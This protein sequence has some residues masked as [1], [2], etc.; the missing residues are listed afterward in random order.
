MA[1]ILVADDDAE[2]RKVIRAILVQQGLEVVQAGDGDDALAM[3]SSESPDLIL[4][5]ILM[6]GMNGFDVLRK[7]KESKATQEIP[8]IVIS[9]LTAADDENQAMRSGA[10]DYVT[11]PWS[12]GELEDR[13][14]IALP[15]LD[16]DKSG[17]GDDGEIR[18][19]HDGTAP[20]PRLKETVAISTGSD[21][22]DKAL[23]GGVP[24]GSLT[25]LEGA[26]GTGKSVMCQHLAFGALLAEQGVAYYVHGGSKEDL[27]S[28]M[29]ELG[30][31]VED[32]LN[33]G[34]LLIHQLNQ[35]YGKVGDADPGL[36]RLL[37]HVQGLPWDMNVI[38]MDSLT[39][40]VNKASWTDTLSFLV[41]C[42]SL[43]RLAKTIVI[44]LHTSAF[45]P[46]MLGKLNALFGTHLSFRVEGFTQ[47]LQL[48]TMNVMEV[49]K[50]KEASQGSNNSVYFEVDPELGIS[51][52]MSLKVLPIFR[53]KG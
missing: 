18:S 39:Q 35:F 2:V 53:I 50:I 36:N 19:P 24:L 17:I 6:P 3:A 9:G 41:E 29:E 34:Q 37:E 14:R 43:C 7:L 26:T 15:Y 51:M 27:V 32:N 52:N 48:K 28:G 31:E 33:Q 40:M 38:I 8:V 1:K 22:I 47:G 5:D 23:L 16:A 44:C 45:D 21:Q 20:D 46:E 42:K 25:L 13:I 4:L 30:L 11:K 49:A 12:P 10:L